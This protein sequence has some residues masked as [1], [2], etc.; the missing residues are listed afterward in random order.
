[1]DTEELKRRAGPRV[2]VIVCRDGRVLMAKHEEDDIEYWCLPGGALEEGEAP[3]DGAL[4]ELREEA[5]VDGRILR[6]VGQA[7]DASGELDTVTF[8]VDIGEQEPALGHDPELGRSE[9]ILIAIEWRTLREIP[10]RD[11]VFLWR[12]GLL[13]I[14]GFLDEI[15]GWGG[16]ISYPGSAGSRSRHGRGPRRA[17]T[18]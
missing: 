11:R 17:P 4:R 9:A 18:G 10:E 6:R 15:S 8:W 7:F 12:A 16:D 1:M 3:E 5:D 13:S 14:P 2:Q